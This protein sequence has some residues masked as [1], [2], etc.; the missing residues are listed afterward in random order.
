MYVWRET[1]GEVADILTT[2]V[3]LLDGGQFDILHEVY[4]VK[5]VVLCKVSKSFRKTRKWRDINYK[6][7]IFLS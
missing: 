4:F 3:H 6:R 2:I 7:P 5:Y 1:F